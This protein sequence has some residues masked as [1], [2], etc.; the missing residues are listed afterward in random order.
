MYIYYYCTGRIPLLIS[1]LH[2]VFCILPPVAYQKELDRLQNVTLP[3]NHHCGGD[4]ATRPTCYTNFEPHFNPDNRLNKVI[5]PTSDFKKWKT[6]R[7]AKPGWEKLG[8]KDVK[9]NFE[10]SQLLLSLSFR[11]LL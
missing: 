5:I 7:S 2:P 6:T 1:C 8:F 4:C 10:V 3:K 11:A 9:V